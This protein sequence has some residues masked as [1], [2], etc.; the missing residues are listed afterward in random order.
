MIAGGGSLQGGLPCCLRFGRQEGKQ[1]G[2]AFLNLVSAQ[3]NPFA[4]AIVH[5]AYQSRGPQGLE[6]MCDRLFRNRQLKR[7]ACSFRVRWISS[8]FNHNGPAMAVRQR[9][10]DDA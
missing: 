10:Q 4:V 7:I 5:I 2:E 8:Q 1:A 9:R 6:M 3:G